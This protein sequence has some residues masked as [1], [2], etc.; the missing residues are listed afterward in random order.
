MGH[1]R[2]Y[3]PKKR[4]YHGNRKENAVSNSVVDDASVLTRSEA[5]LSNSAILFENEDE[6]LCGNRIIDIAVLISVFSALCCPVCFEKDLCLKED[7]KFG[8]AS[9][10][11]LMCNKCSFMT[12]FSSSKKSNQSYETNLLFVFGLRL[13]GKGFTAAKKL[14]S[15]LNMPVL[16]KFSFRELEKK[17]KNATTFCAKESMNKAAAEVKDVRK[18]KSKIIKCGVSVDGSWQKRGYSSLNG[19]VSAI[20][21][22]TGKVLD[23][24]TLSQFC[25]ICQ[26]FKNAKGSHESS[27]ANHS[28]LMN[29][30]GS[31]ASMESVG[32]YRIFERSEV[33][34]GLQYSDYYGDGDSKGYLSVKN[35]YGK[36]S[37]QKLECIGHVQKR[38]GSR[39]RKLKDSVPSLKGKGKLT[40][41]L[42]DKIQNYYG[43]AIRSNV[44][45][46]SSMQSA[47]IAAF[48]H[49]CS[50]AKKPM[51][52]QCPTGAESWCKYQ[53]CAATGKR[54][55][56][57]S[58]GLPESI[59]N[60]VKPVYME[61]C[62]NKL[63]K[64]CLHGQ[65][66]NANESFNN[67]FWTIIPKEV[68]VEFTTFC[69]G[70]N[71]AVIQFNNGYMG[72]IKVLELLNIV[73]GVYTLQGYKS[74]DSDRIVD[75]K[76]HSLQSAKVT[77][78]ILRASRKKKSSNN[79]VKEGPTYKA[80]EF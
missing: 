80:G 66:Q 29:H 45:N 14:C 34:R 13:L 6:N 55:S 63:L 23:I 79:E 28:C 51:H 30:K 70:S 8:L 57:K 39:L 31:A 4:K 68:F 22:E 3:R 16:S 44:G 25:R 64:K 71:I 75:S 20:S 41:A 40:D 73:P 24:E 27:I 19:Y 46:L 72:F 50:S 32:A 10:F 36:D 49:C 60:T 26:R 18:N 76:R 11:C 69:L 37:V 38:V 48:F 21:I 62:D 54:F 56:E 67:V 42:I 77:R 15:T 47:T 65:T 12:G 52:G 78:K 58:K 2:T 59:I 61:L 1:N 53:Q 7:S 35:I 17:I 5:K 33:L 74:I 9:N 43:I